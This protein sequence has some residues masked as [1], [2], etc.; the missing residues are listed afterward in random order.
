MEHI[1]KIAERIRNVERMFDVRQGLTRADDILPKKFFDTP[2]PKGN[3]KEQSSI[4][5]SSRR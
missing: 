3:T 4:D 2:L 5:Q 1:V